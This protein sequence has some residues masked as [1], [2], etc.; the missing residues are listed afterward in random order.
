MS[1]NTAKLSH[2]PTVSGFIKLSDHDC[3]QN[4]T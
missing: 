2:G 4:K 1:L 3:A